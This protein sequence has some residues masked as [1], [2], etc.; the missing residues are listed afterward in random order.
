MSGGTFRA[1]RVHAEPRAR[2]RDVS[3][4]VMVPLMRSAGLGGLNRARKGRT[5]RRAVASRPAPGLVER[6]FSASGPDELWVADI[7]YVPR[8]VGFRFIGRWYNPGRRH[9]SLGYEAPAS[10]EVREGGTERRPEVIP[11]IGV[12]EGGR[13]GRREP[14]SREAAWDGR[15]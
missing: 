1:Q 3:A 14:S 7:T 10:F 15:E 5:N 9:S 13:F 11:Y 8:W 12:S 6:N 2:D 4:T